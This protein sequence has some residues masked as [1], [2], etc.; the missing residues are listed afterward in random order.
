MFGFLLFIF[1]KFGDFLAID[2]HIFFSFVF[3]P[4]ETIVTYVLEHFKLSHRSLS[5]C[6][7]FC[8]IFFPLSFW[9]DNLY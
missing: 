3:P 9:L 7:L 6:L 8:K 5:L 4:T 2:L 1:T